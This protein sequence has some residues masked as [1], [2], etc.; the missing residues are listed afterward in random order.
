MDIVLSPLESFF[1]PIFKPFAAIIHVFIMLIKLIEWIVL[2]IIW[3]I[4]F[5]IWVFMDLLDPTKLFGEFFNSLM[6]IIIALFSAFLNIIKGLFA[7]V[8]NSIANWMQGFWGWDQ[9]SLTKADKNS[10]YFSGINRKK[11]TKY[12]LTNSNTVP[13]S[14]IFGTILCPPMGVFM[15]MGITGWLNIV[16]CCLLTLLFYLPGLFYALLII[17]T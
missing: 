12:Y 11:G 6:V 13:F 1:E 14:V 4:Q 8:I 15:D 5:I 3:F 17:Y 10:K 2:F 9:S 16:V 7:I